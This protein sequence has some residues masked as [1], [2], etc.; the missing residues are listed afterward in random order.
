MNESRG[1]QPNHETQEIPIKSSRSQ[2]IEI[3]REFLTLRT[4]KLLDKKVSDYLDKEDFPN[5]EVSR[6][7]VEQK[8][9]LEALFG[10]YKGGLKRDL[11]YHGTGK[12]KYPGEKYKDKVDVTKKLPV[13]ETVLRDGL[14]VHHD[15]WFPTEDIES[16][17]LAVS[18]LYAKWF[19]DKFQPD[20]D[21]LQWQF[22]DP[23]DFFRFFMADTFL[24]HAEISNLPETALNYI[25]TRSKIKQTKKE[26]TAQ[27][28]NRL[29]N[30][31][32]STRS[33]VN[34]TTPAKNLLYGKTDIT[35]NW[36]AVL[37]LDRNQIETFNLPLGGA[38]EIR[39]KHSIPPEA[40]RAVMVPLRHMDEAKATIEKTGHQMQ[41][42]AMECADLY[43][44]GFPI[45]D[46]VART[47]R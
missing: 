11:L 3:G 22:G 44:A 41:L 2:K 10:E 34:E 9:G 35:D 17:S 24:K 6:A 5:V 37:C 25:A 32:S 16:I 1:Q 38:H 46:L 26:R 31:I 30:W 14:A 19:A 28:S 12:L 13:L 39:T 4:P 15:Q 36:G 27:N 8:A 7:Y 42:F 29:F 47:E 23:N 20:T 43:L 18:Y 33:D 40:I 45:E 21:E